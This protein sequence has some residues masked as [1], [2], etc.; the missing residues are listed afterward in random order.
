MPD[1]VQDPPGGAFGSMLSRL[2]DERF[3]LRFRR[4]P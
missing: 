1:D 2:G 4:D 3:V